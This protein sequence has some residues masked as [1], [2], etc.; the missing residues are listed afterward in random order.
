MSDD[1]VPRDSQ[2]DRAALERII[3][4]AAELQ[5]GER[6]I[7]E[8]L[9]EAEVMQLGNDVGISQTHLR[10]AMLEERTRALVPK[11][12]G[13]V[14]RLVGP[15]RITAERVVTGGSAE[16]EAKLN[17][18]MSEGELLQVKRRY[19]DSTS[20]ER[21]EGAWASLRRSLGVGGRKYLLARAREV[22]SRV[23]SIE[24]G[25]SLVQLMADLSNT[26]NE[27]LLGSGLTLGSALAT[28]GVAL[29]IGVMAPVAA[30][31]AVLGA[32]IAYSI[33]RDR[34][35][36]VDKFQVALEQILDKLEH[37]DL[38]TRPNTPPPPF[39]VMERIA[40]EVRRNLGLSDGG[41]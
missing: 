11:E 27:Y 41:R 19:P 5:A 12:A 22:V 18:W 6:D 23:T 10:Q 37:G 34:R 2:F 4:R 17:D 14:T 1:L 26:R 40:G 13:P 15:R 16:L 33:A 24:R 35:R 8:V 32:P 25:R 20:W 30:I 29:V 21:K 36:Q 9:T 3:H 31:P 38:D 28:S 7:G 39:Q